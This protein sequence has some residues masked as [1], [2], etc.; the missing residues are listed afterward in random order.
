METTHAQEDE[1]WMSLDLLERLIERDDL[2]SALRRCC[3][4][5]HPTKGDR[6]RVGG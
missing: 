3:L 1:E 2:H 5:Q 6:C 4:Q